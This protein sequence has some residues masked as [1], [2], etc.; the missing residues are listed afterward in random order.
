MI[1]SILAIVGFAATAVVIALTLYLVTRI[2]A[3]SSAKPLPGEK[4]PLTNIAIISTV[5]VIALILILDIE[6]TLTLQNIRESVSALLETID[7]VVMAIVGV[8]VLIMLTL[9]NRISKKQRTRKT[10]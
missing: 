3:W 9:L 4:N 5:L 8:V 7:L 10:R 6:L 2:L 1:D